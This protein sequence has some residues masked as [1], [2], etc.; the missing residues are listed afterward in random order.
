MTLFSQTCVSVLV[1]LPSVHPKHSID[2]YCWSLHI[3]LFGIPNY[4]NFMICDHRLLFPNTTFRTK[5]NIHIFSPP[6][7]PLLWWLQPMHETARINTAVFI[8]VAPPDGATNCCCLLWKRC[9]VPGKYATTFI[10]GLRN[11]RLLLD[12]LS[13]L[14]VRNSTQQHRENFLSNSPPQS[15][16]N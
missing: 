3:A 10:V 16:I 9:R 6:I 5:P 14:A 1:S 4:N 8:Q 13:S 12:A 15:S 2:L 11:A 7:S